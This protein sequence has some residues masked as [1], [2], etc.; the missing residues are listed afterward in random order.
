MKMKY[1]NNC[2]KFKIMESQVVTAISSA[3]HPSEEA[4]ADFSCCAA[5]TSV[6]S[7]QGVWKQTLFKP[8]PLGADAALMQQDFFVMFCYV[9]LLCYDKK[10]KQ[11]RGQWIN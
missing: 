8:E 4:V 3:E 1:S 9:F 11:V 5:V 6:G 7:V 2:K 10:G